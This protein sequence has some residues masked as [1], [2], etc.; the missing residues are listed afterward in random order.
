MEEKADILYKVL[1][2]FV[3]NEEN[4]HVYMDIW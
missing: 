3:S 2:K 4:S 1:F